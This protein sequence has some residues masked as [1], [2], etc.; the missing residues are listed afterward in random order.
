MDIENDGQAAKDGITEGGGI[1]GIRHRLEAFNGSLEI[2]T[3]KP[4]TIFI[5]IP[6]D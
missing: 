4:F 2:R 3:S 5:K 6:D 1:K